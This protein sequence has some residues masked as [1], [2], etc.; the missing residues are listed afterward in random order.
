MDLP[1]VKILKHQG[2]KKKT[3]CGNKAVLEQKVFFIQK[4]PYLILLWKQ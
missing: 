3:C 1:N 4:K 2:K